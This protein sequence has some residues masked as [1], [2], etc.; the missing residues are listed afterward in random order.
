M[1]WAGMKRL[2]T[3]A[4]IL[5]LGACA[6]TAGNAEGERTNWRCAGDKEFSLR[7]VSNSVE[8]FVAGQTHRLD[9]VAGAD[10]QY[11]NGNVTY[12][13]NGGRPTLTGVFGEPY[14]NCQRKR[15]DWWFDFW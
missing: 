14:E 13:E 7:H 4:A 11:S 10:R 5:A 15:S 12:T 6:S 1:R 2:M 9:P 8:V 3:A